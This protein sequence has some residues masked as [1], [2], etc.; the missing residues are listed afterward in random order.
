MRFS[1]G[2][3]DDFPVIP[4]ASSRCVNDS[5]CLRSFVDS[6]RIEKSP[7]RRTTVANIWLNRRCQ[8]RL[9]RGDIHIKQLI[10]MVLNEHAQLGSI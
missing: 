2:S 10:P 5:K 4:C 3:I 1:I 8:G 9:W 7:K 6:K